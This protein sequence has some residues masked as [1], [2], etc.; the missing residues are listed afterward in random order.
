MRR[1]AATLLVVS[2]VPLL[3][4]SSGGSRKPPGSSSDESNPLYSFTLMRQ[5]SVLLQQGNYEE[6]LKRLEEADRHRPGNASV[7]NMIGLCH[8]RMGAYDLALASFNRALDY[9]PAFTDARNNR[10]ATYLAMGQNHLAEVDFVSVLSDPTYPHRW[11]AY[12][13]LG[14]TYLQRGQPGAA[15]ENF[16]QAANAASPV[17][18]AFLRLAEIAQQQGR[19]EA[20]IQWLEEAH[21]KFPERSEGSMELGRLLWHLGRCPEARPYLERVIS[22]DP[23]SQMATDARSMLEG[24]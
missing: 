10:G 23:G 4:C 19:T 8:L 22:A 20:A 18:D 12:Y 24:C 16:R 2:L 9:I 1:L 15:E 6:A 3:A 7:Y 13:N 11:Q 14:M 5:G 17:F 21:F